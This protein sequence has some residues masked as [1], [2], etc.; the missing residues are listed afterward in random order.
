MLSAMRRDVLHPL[1][2][3]ATLLGATLLVGAGLAHAEPVVFKL[4]NHVPAGKRPTLTV[5]AV[6]RIHNLKL[7]LTREEDAGK[8]EA[9]HAI[10]KAGQTLVLPIGDGSPGVAH[11]KGTLTL[12]MDDGASWESDLQFDTLVEGAL[13]ITYA[14]DH[15]DLDKRVL[16]FQSTRPVKEAQLV[17]IGDDGRELGTGEATYEGKPANTWLPIAWEQTRPA[18]VMTMKLRVVDAGGLATQLTLTPWS[19]EIPHQE[20]NFATGS[21]AIEA[22]EAGKL[23]EAY[24]RIVAAWD[25]ARP[26]VRCKLYIAGH[27]DTVG[28][29]ESNARLSIERARVSANPFFL[30]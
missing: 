1:F 10:V 11:Y 12:A 25:K 18:R 23:D 5:H 22:R 8:V 20:V 27:T 24:G 14:R 3:V 21:A 30:K 19:V 13:R 9:R 6:T 7:D 16:E 4:Q 15:L 29:R 26:Y 17:V 2:V 28:T